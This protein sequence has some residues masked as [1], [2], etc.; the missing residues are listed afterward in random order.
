MTIPFV[1]ETPNGTKNMYFGYIFGAS[2][3]SYNN[4]CVPES[5]K[6]VI[7]TGGQKINANAFYE[8]KSLERVEIQSGV[9]SIGAY[10]FAGCNNLK[11]VTIE[12]GVQSIGQ[13]AFSGY[14]ANIRALIF[15]PNS[16]TTVGQYAFSG[17][18]FCES[19][20]KPENW[21]ETQ[22]GVIYFGV[23][24][25]DVIKQNE[26]IF[27]IQNESAILVNYLGNETSLDIPSTIEKD[28][29]QYNVT[30]I[31][32]SSFYHNIN[33]NEITIPSSITSIGSYAFYY[34]TNLNDVTMEEGVQ[35]IGSYAFE[36]C[37]NLQSL[38]IP[39][40]IQTIGENALSTLIEIN[41]TNLASWLK[42]KFENANAN[43]L[44]NDQAVLKLNS[45]ELIKW[46][47]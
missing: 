15:I 30:T 25:D 9:Q 44:S 38:I 41:I 12:E 43:P 18:V 34:C 2:S 36:G 19:N 6:E 13:Y 14:D 10:A 21:E 40:S 31:E 39:S 1:G 4:A 5:L 24:K 8:C 11:E 3:Y 7:I 29:K 46:I 35:S 23:T 20:T 27:L 45:E 47:S 37:T 28:N 22:Y 42:I 33:L 32:D 26:T 16:V 17:Y